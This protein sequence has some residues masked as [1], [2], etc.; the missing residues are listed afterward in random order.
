MILSASRRTDIPAFYSEWF[1]N[2][3]KEGYLCVR[4]PLNLHQVSKITLSTDVIDCIVFWTKNP[5][6]MIPKLD[7]L[8]NYNYY[9]QFTLTGY[10]KDIEANLPDKKEKLIPAFIQLSEEIGSERVIWRYDPIIFNQKYTPEYH[11]HAFSEIA[12]RLKGYTEK[13]VI[14]FVDVYKKNQ[15][16]LESL[17]SWD[18]DENGLIDFCRKL[19]DIA[20]ANDMVIATCAEKI[21]L[22]AVGIEHNA[23]I[24]SSVIEKITGGTVKVK[25]DSAQREECKCVASIETGTYNTCLNGCKYC[26]A[27]Y[28]EKTL[29][30]NVKKYDPNSPILCDSIKPDDKITEKP[31]KSVIDYHIKLG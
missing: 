4:N 25:K 27:N 16:N 20:K 13:S 29:Q 26:Y 8:K 1:I 5:I 23:C 31:M 18:L 14:S 21:D 30:K 2:R 17:N 15:K 7:S 11:I 24:D 6:P 19:Y 10:G 9:F 12:S 3:I 28:S 22:S